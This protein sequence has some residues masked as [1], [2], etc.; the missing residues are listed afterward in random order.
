MSIALPPMPPS[1]GTRPPAAEPE[2]G[3]EGSGDVADVD[4][5]VLQLL[6]HAPDDRLRLYSLAAARPYR[7]GACGHDQCAFVLGVLSRAGEQYRV[8]PSCFSALALRGHRDSDA[9]DPPP[10][11]GS[12]G[13]MAPMPRGGVSGGT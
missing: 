7:C 12:G 6:Y 13:S 8:C 3:H 11:P 1:T 4:E 9:P 5:G 10:G 2:A